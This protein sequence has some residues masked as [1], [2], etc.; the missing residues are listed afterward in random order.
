MQ[1]MQ[2]DREKIRF[3]RVARGWTQEELSARVVPPVTQQAVGQWE[4]LGV[5]S[6]RTLEKIAAALGVLP[7]ALL[8]KDK[9]GDGK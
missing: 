1:F 8:K 5:G 6:F 7:E 2:V 4:R 9:R 3:F